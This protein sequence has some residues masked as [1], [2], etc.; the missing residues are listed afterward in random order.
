VTSARQGD[1]GNPPPVERLIRSF[2]GMPGIGRRSAERMAMHVLRATSEEAEELMT[3]MR[4]IRE[5]VAPCSY[6]FNLTECDPCRIC[7]DGARDRSLLMV[8]EQSRD[9]VNFESSGFFR[10]VYHVL[11][12]TID[13]LSGI[14]PEDLTIGQLLAR[15][16]D[17]ARNCGGISISEIILGLNPTLEGDGTSLY[18][19]QLLE[20]R[21]VAVSRLARGIPSG[22]QL[23]FASPAVLADA[24]A[25]RQ[26]VRE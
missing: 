6:C 2:I 25:G 10:G 24:I 3:A 19:G 5:R 16:D 8:V 14:Q 9:L 26:N 18:L 1:G 12:G 4:E 22:S 21:K 7:A 17:P 11:G 20:S 15:I 13:P 23:D